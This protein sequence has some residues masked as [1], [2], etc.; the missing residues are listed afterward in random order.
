MKD[1]VQAVGDAFKKAR[2]EQ[3][4]TLESVAEKSNVDVR[5]V[6]NIEQYRGNPKLGKR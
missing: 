2:F 6:I 3:G 4:L 5:T 1:Y